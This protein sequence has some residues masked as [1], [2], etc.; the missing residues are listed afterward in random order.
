[1]AR[2]TKGTHRFNNV[3]S[4]EIKSH[5]SKEASQILLKE[6]RYRTR[7]KLRKSK[8]NQNALKQHNLI[9]KAFP[10]VNWLFVII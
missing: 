1:M 8:I 9:L 4:Y 3:S 10:I 5:Q 6:R 7:K 2:I